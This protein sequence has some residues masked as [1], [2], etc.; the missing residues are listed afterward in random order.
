MGCG[1]S[2][3][4]TV[5]NLDRA[6]PF[7]YSGETITGNVVF[8]VLEETV[9]VDELVLKFFG[10]V[11]YTTQQTVV[12]NGQPTTQTIPHEIPVISSNVVLARPENGQEE[13]TFG[14]GQHTFP[15]QIQLPVNIPPSLNSPGSQ[16]H[17]CYFVQMYVDRA[18]YK[19]NTRENKYVTVFPRVN[20]SQV[21][22]ASNPVPFSTQNQAN[23]NLNGSINKL[24]YIAGETIQGVLNIENP[25]QIIIKQIMVSLI[26]SFIMGSASGEHVITSKPIPELMRR[27]DTRLSQAFTIAIPATPLPPSYQFDGG[28]S[29]KTST[30]TNYL[31]KFQVQLESVSGNN[32]EILVPI[33]IGTD[34]IPS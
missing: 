32:F 22:N 1:S 9:N 20:L 33:I 30:R 13:L 10:Q 15:F 2:S 28:V 6:N 14:K 23:L 29:Q 24:G 11:A 25:R 27:Q 19:A 26:R 17:V 8:D 12:L 3:S 18:W 31:L 5:V 21:S 7:Y 34:P 16:P 4:T